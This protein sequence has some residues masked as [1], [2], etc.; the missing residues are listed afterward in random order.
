MCRFR[1]SQTNL[2]GGIA[3]AKE[4]CWFIRTGNPSQF[5]RYTC[6]LLAI[7][8]ADG[9]SSKR[10][11]C[12]DPEAN[13]SDPSGGIDVPGNYTSGIVYAQVSYSQ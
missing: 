7:S 12:N 2:A 13:I 3:I 9:V 10:R 1:N 6:S 11:V 5:P 8:F 4:Q